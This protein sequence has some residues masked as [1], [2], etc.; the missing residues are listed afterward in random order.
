MIGYILE[1]DLEYCWELHDLHN[2]YP[3]Y[4]EKIEVSHDMLSGY[5]RNIADRYGIKVGGVKN[6]FL[7][8]LIR[9]DMLFIIKICGI[10]CH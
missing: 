10:T 9:S 6:C 7:I 2:D 4:S 3:L 5:C 8:L 1:V